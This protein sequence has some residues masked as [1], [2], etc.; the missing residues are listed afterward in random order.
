MI[1][2]QLSRCE[3]ISCAVEVSPSSYFNAH[4]NNDFITR[5]PTIPLID[6]F[7][8]SSISNRLIKRNEIEIIYTKENETA[9]AYIESH[10]NEIS[11]TYQ[12]TVVTSDYLEQ[13]VSFSKGARRLSSSRFYNDMTSAMTSSIKEY[14]N[15]RVKPLNRPLEYLKDEFEEDE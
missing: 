5:S 6:F 8:V 9:D 1:D 14:E 13:I 12:V 10:L 15:K 3:I 11:K 7:F 2:L 4:S